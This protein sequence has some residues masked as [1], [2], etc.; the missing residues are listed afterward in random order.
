MRK[1]CLASAESGRITSKMIVIS[2]HE[3]VDRE[4]DREIEK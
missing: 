1:A 2:K 4:I 3:L